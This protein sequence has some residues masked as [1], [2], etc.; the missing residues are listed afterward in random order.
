MKKQILTLGIVILFIV[1]S[2]TFIGCGNSTSNEVE[3]HE[4]SEGHNHSDGHVHEHGADNNDSDENTVVDEGEKAKDLSMIIETYLQLKNGLAGDD[5]KKTAEAAE[6]M[7]VAFSGFDK[8]SLDESKLSEY[9][10][11]EESAIENAEHISK[12]EIY[13]QREHFVI[14]SEDINDL[15]TLIG[16]DKK[17]FLDFCPMANNNKGATW[18]SEIEEI[19]NPYMGSKM[20]KCGKVQLEI[21]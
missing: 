8:S 5:E 14:L 19:S 10:E 20:P 11:I 17:L 13:H 18:L 2:A 7:L 15:I 3:S 4:H 12:S 1:G 16:T 21:N 9:S 6:K